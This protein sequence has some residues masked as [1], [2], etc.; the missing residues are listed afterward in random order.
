MAVFAVA[1]VCLV[2]VAAVFAGSDERTIHVFPVSATSEGWMKGALAL[3]Q[4]LGEQAVFSD[5]TSDNA[6]FLILAG[7]EQSSGDGATPSVDSSTEQGAWGGDELVPTNDGTQEGGES[8]LDV[9]ATDEETAT[10]ETV[11]EDGA[12][13]TPEESAPAVDSETSTAGEEGGVQARVAPM[14]DLSPF[15]YGIDMLRGVVGHAARAQED[16]PHPNPL[17]R[18][19]G[20]RVTAKRNHLLTTNTL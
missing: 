15:A 3:E 4:T 13:D 2:T 17:P 5:F 10:D 18:G 6:A 8:S 1:L 14:S 7:K 16:A 9:E 11:S 20:T 19:E 12:V